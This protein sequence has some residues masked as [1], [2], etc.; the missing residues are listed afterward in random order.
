MRSRLFIIPLVMALSVAVPAPCGVDEAAHPMHV[1]LLVARTSEEALAILVRINAGED[2]AVLARQYSIDPSASKGGDLGSVDPGNLK[3]ELREALRGVKPGQVSAVVK[4]PSGYAILKIEKQPATE[5]GADP[6][7]I[8]IL[9]AIKKIRLTPDESGY[10]EFYEAFRNKLPTD[11]QLLRAWQMDLNGVCATRQ[12]APLDGIQA[13]RKLIA[14]DAGKMEPLRLAYSHYTLAQLLSSRRDFDSAIKELQVAYQLS[15]AAP[16]NAAFVAHMEE[17]LGI[18]YLHRS[19]FTDSTIAPVI[20]SALIFPS[21]A[22][23]LHT[24]RA[25]GEKAIE[26]LSKCWKR[27]PSNTEVQW[28]LNLAYMTLDGYPAQVPNEFLIPPSVFQSKEDL[29]RF[30][31]VAPAAGLA[32]YGNAG[33]VIIDDFDN[34]GLLDVITSQVDDCAPLHYFHNNGDG[35]FTDRAREAGLAGQM[36]GLNIIQADY[37]NDGCMDILVLRGGWEIPRHNSLLRNNCDGTFTDVTERSGLLAGPLRSS[38]S[39]V[40]ADIDN[41]GSLD[42]FIANENAPSQLF[43]NNG[44]GTF[45]D[46]SHQAGIDRVA[47]SK[48]VVSADYDNDGYPDFY[49]SNFNGFNFLYHNNGDR[50]FSEV[51]RQ[52]GVREP[53]MSFA[54]WFFD[55]DNDGWPDLFVTTYFLSVEEAARGYLGLPRQQETAK[56]Y[57]NLGN[58]SFQDVTADVHLDRVFMP[59]GANFGDIDNDGFPDIYLGS[60][61]PSLASLVPN[62]LLHNQEGKRFTDISASSGTGALA[63]GHGIAFGDL[64]NDGD[65]DI[66]AVM[67]G[68]QPGDRSPTRLFENPG[69]HGN[70]WITVRLV[71]VRSNRGAIGARIA[72]TVI[73]EGVKRRTIYRT[74]GSGGSFGASPLQQHIGLGKSAKIEFLEVV[75]PAS[76]TKQTFAN[77]S[78][79]QFVEIKEFEKS[80]TKLTRPT[81]ELGGPARRNQSRIPSG[82]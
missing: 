79:N 47:V 4:I 17:V 60:G 81:F 49:V 67:G 54:A 44:D 3:I 45:T 59:M 77:L 42:L 23:T 28:L 74:V 80:F 68:P 37:N 65:E 41:D 10:G 71:G 76:K 56:L 72:V 29:G 6:D 53:W 24:I 69:Q 2:F 33:G 55:Y 34:D 82:G 1:A 58:G 13:V 8:R 38:H 21:H 40:W 25:D 73:N 51:S 11:P 35:T 63:K 48:A 15:L 75:W 62:V 22:G 31:D 27:D 61:N 30:L 46:I 16:D 20:N 52:A 14:N 43:L 70:D 50:T 66:V 64:N 57:R 9:N 39:A 26:Y 18:N 36:G 32:T 5:T 19:A 7:R 78:V 12:L